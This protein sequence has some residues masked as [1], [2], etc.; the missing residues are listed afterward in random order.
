MTPNAKRGDVEVHIK[1][2]VKG[3]GS[4]T[5][6]ANG[7]L[8]VDELRV[9]HATMLRI[10]IEPA[11][12]QIAMPTPK[13]A[14]N[15]ESCAD[16]N[17]IEARNT[18]AVRAALLDTNLSV[19]IEQLGVGSVAVQA[20]PVSSLGLGSA[21]FMAHYGV[22]FPMYT[23]A[24]AKGI[25]SADLVIAAGQRGMLGSFGA[26]GLPLAKVA[27][28]LDKIQATLGK[29]PFAINLIHSP[30]DDLL[31]ERNVD[32]FLDRGV[33]I[34]EA[35]AFMKLTPHVVRYRLAG[36]ERNLA[37]GKTICRNSIIFKVSRTELADMALRPAPADI[38]E[39]LLRAGKVTAEQAALAATVPMCDD[40]AVEAD[41]GGHT[42]NRPLQVLL[43][44]I[45]A[46]RDAVA[47]ET[48]VRVRIGAGGGIG[49]P[50]AVAATFT[51]GADFV[52]TGTINQ[53]A[54]QSGTCDKVREQLSQAT[55]SDVVMA[56]AADMFESG[57]KLQVLK[58]GTMFP[59]RALKLYEL[60]LEY[61]SIEA[62]PKKD[63][64]RLEKTVFRKKLDTVW[65]ETVDF[66]LNQ[67]KDP[68][69]IAR[70][71]KD[72]KGKMALIFRWYLGL[73]SGWANAG[74]NDRSMDFQVWCG[75]AIGSFNDFIRGTYLD[76]TVAKAYHD[77]YE[78][79]MQLLRGACV[80]RR[81]EQLKA[82]TGVRDAVDA[83]ALAPYRP[84][85][86]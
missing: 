25:A 84:A 24:M 37:T 82:H 14:L 80:L 77:V 17:T 35:S 30:F 43:P 62:I 75:P 57:V 69:K 15:P 53:M 79:N 20:V 2:V 73:S 39:K 16:E 3:A 13:H 59:S 45:L 10:R 58:K 41:S 19:L 12:G 66:T 78:A 48:G 22:D 29:K 46:R 71:E 31:E 26:G 51:M 86:I 70:A 28:G 44:V 49:C 50:E 9:Y 64:E 23:G 60:F 68:E 63:R 6:I 38:V 21:A 8:Y 56:P 83:A 32:L 67:L 5:V 65:Q 61:P 4:V 7:Y 40:I 52:V 34:V 42:D 85:P 54:R 47:A 76:P 74:V 27:A 18:A 72:P 36:L 81:I 1:S 11:V 55:Y 33:R